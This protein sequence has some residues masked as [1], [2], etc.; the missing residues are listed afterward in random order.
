MNP[1][2]IR[3]RLIPG[4]IFKPPPGL[5]NS[6]LP[7]LRSTAVSPWNPP[8]WSPPSV[9]F[10]AG[11]SSQMFS[12]NFL[13]GLRAPP[14]GAE[15]TQTHDTNICSHYPD[16]RPHVYTIACQHR[17]DEERRGAR[18]STPHLI[19]VIALPPLQKSAS[20]LP[21]RCSHPI[22]APTSFLFQC[23]ICSGKKTQ[24]NGEVIWAL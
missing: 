14:C 12:A 11:T 16:I 21:T 19:H 3:A 6:S 2:E 9:S 4:N 8:K 22:I 18:L 24:K 5:L 20:R 7:R 17:E 13:R 10:S 23:A 1:G 15:L